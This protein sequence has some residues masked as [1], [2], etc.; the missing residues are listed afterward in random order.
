MSKLN[1]LAQDVAAELKEHEAKITAAKTQLAALNSAHKDTQA[2][3]DEI[4]GRLQKTKAQLDKANSDAATIIREAQTQ[5]SSIVGEADK[6]NREA[7]ATMASAQANA[8]LIVAKA[9][10]D[11]YRIS[12][13]INDNLAELA[14]VRGEV[15][16]KKAELTAMKK[17]ARD[18]SDN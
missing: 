17:N 14:R 8:R 7:E 12:Q 13:D 4:H 6:L 16:A 18:W 1:Q 2:A 9:Q 10:A 3:V 5:A 15:N 11:V